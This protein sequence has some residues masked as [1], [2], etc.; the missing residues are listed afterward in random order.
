M[1]PRRDLAAD[2]GRCLGPAGKA[3]ADKVSPLLHAVLHALLHP[4]E[5]VG[6][7]LLCGLDDVLDHRLDRLGDS[8]FLVLLR[9]S[10]GDAADLQKCVTSWAAPPRGQ[11]VRLAEFETRLAD[12]S[13]ATV[14][15]GTEQKEGRSK[16]SRAHAAPF[17]DIERAHCATARPGAPLSC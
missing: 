6:R 11:Q 13:R 17:H 16:A 5:A 2:R 10:G 3:A 1:R 4:H 14:T 15:Q 7:V 8:L 12:R 9:G